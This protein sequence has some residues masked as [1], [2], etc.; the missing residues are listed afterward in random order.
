MEVAFL[1][2]FVL[3]DDGLTHGSPRVVACVI[4]LNHV[5]PH[6]HTHSSGICDAT[7][8]TLVQHA[9]WKLISYVF[10]VSMTMV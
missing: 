1:D 6:D 3:Y 2:V 9:M 5:D 10:L 8:A 4:F 7:S